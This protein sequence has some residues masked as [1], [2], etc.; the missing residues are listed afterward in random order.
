VTSLG[1]YDIC[2]PRALTFPASPPTPISIFQIA[3]ET[4]EVTGIFVELIKAHD[5][6]GKKK[7]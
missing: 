4:E 1:E 6:K 3:D 2:S 7:I 5:I